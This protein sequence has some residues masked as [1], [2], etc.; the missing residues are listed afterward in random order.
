MIDRELENNIKR[1]KEFI[2]LWDKFHGIFKN[3]ISE[4]HVGEEDEKAFLSIR[5]L[6]NSRYED[7]MDSLGIKPLKR[8]TMNASLCNVLSLE[9][10]SVMSDERLKA[11]D[12]DWGE[13]SRFLHLLLNRLIRKKKR[14]EG[15]NRFAFVLKKGISKLK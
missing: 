12:R 3:T 8:F 10:L 4:N 1:T 5:E 7:L 14:I 13:S 2:E 9:R 15:F 6:V 11:V